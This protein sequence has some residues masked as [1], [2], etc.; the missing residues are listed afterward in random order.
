M[1]CPFCGNEDDKVVDS[2]LSKDGDAIR[3]RRQCLGCEKRFTTYERI[4]ELETFVIKKD[5]SREIFDRV[6]LRGGI[7]KALQK[8]PVSVNQVEGFL[9]A[10]ESEFQ[11]SN[12]REIA[13][14]EIGEKVINWL[15]GIDDVAYVRFA[16]VYREFRDVQEFMRELESIIAGRQKSKS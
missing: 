7:L 2:R 16:S 11:E 13:A 15:K 8:R 5:G 4:D 14:S 12:V 1:R 6:K 9:D 10:L 3:R